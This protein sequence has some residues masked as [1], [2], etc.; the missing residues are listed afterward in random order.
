MPITVYG[1]IKQHN[2]YI[3]V[4]SEL[5]KGTTF[6]IYLPVMLD[7]ELA[8]GEVIAEP[9]VPKG[10][11]TILIAEDESSL[12]KYVSDV[13]KSL[14]YKV[15]EAG[16]GEEALRIS[17]EH[18]DVIHLLLTDFIMPGINGRELADTLQQDRP[19][20]K[21]IIMSGY[22]DDVIAQHGVLEDGIN[23]LQKPVT[24]IKM[25]SKIREVLDE[26]RSDTAGDSAD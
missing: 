24:V 16:D 20:M 6:E 12:R 9:Q 10:T 22:T 14:G 8:H 19:N 15:L 21:V 25:A 18:E 7:G 11:E 23:F 4:D 3:Y 5:D 13:L 1:I 17:G 26:K 2:G